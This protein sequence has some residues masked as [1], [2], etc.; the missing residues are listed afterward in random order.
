MER[1]LSIHRLPVVEDR[2]CVH[3]QLFA[4]ELL[5]SVRRIVGNT[6]QSDLSLRQILDDP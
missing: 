6:H 5:D 1:K 3:C 4:L 2:H